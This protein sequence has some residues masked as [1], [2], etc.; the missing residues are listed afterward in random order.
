MRTMSIAALL[1]A[2][3]LPAGQGFAQSACPG[4]LS[5]TALQPVPRDAVYGI[6]LR[7]DDATSRALRD[8]V[9][10]ALRARGQRVGEPATHV[11]SWRGG[12]ATDGPGRGGSDPFR[13]DDSDRFHES[14]DLH[15]MQ[16][17][18]RNRRPGGA[19][20]AQR[21]NG[22]VELRDRATGRVV[23]TAVLSCDRRGNDQAALICTLVG[24]VVPAIG[25]TVAGRAF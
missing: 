5:A 12:L 3:L 22:S 24:A 4:H 16:D 8:Q 14:D 18:P 11:L 2:A 13:F 7:S 6:A 10:A 23:W 9:F 17:L 20:A 21:L 19:P 15:W 25:Q 1:L